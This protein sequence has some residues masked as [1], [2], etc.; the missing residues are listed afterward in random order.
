MGFPIVF[1]ET[2][3]MGQKRLVKEMK[4]GKGPS[5]EKPSFVAFDNKTDE[6]TYIVKWI[7]QLIESGK[8]KPEE[9]AVISSKR[10]TLAGISRL[11]GRENFGLFKGKSSSWI[12]IVHV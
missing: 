2:L 3:T 8:A 12:F 11:L 10:S 6:R 1:I 4:S 7:K 9:I 5:G